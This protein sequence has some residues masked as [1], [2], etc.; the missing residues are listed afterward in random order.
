LSR[1]L[2]LAFLCALILHSLVALVRLDAFKKPISVKASPKTL[3]M[4]IVVPQ[5]VKKTSIGNNPSIAFKKPVE[6][7]K[8]EKKVKPKQRVTPK[9]A[10]KKRVQLKRSIMKEALP[11]KDEILADLSPADFPA[12]NEKND[13]FVK[14]DTVFIPDMV[15]IPKALPNINNTTHKEKKDGVPN[16]VPDIPIAYALPDYK[17][18][19]SP[20]YPLLARKRGYQGTVLLEV[21]VSKGGK[22]DSIRVARS[23]GYK[24]LDK[25]AIKGVRDWLFH[26]ARRGDDLIEM[27]VKIPIHFQLK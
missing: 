27:W 3:T 16:P 22:A 13:I 15:D 11:E 6:K 10:R 18:N 4:D 14:E 2:I 19:I 21:L 5:P 17:S 25:A 7:K 26:P 9:V 20:Q 1:S 23:S 8:M 12:F 24:I